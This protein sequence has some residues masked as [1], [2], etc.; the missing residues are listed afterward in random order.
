MFIDTRFNP[1]N[2][3]P[4]A[5]SINDER[6]ECRDCQHLINGLCMAQSKKS[7][8]PSAIDIDCTD[9]CEHFTPINKGEVIDAVCS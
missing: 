6:E 7:G 5:W 2:E 9:E 3:L 4:E 8:V 1:D